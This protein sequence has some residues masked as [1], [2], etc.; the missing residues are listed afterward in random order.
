[1]ALVGASRESRCL[2]NLLRARIR[3]A[4]GAGLNLPHGQRILGE[5]TH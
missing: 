1:M 5:F 4:S 2:L 3:A